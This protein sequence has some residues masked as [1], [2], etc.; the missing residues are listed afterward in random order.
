MTNFA[1]DTPK[2]RARTLLLSHIAQFS[3]QRYFGHHS[4][5]GDPE[6]SFHSDREPPVGSLIA[7]NAAPPSKWYLSWLHEIKHQPHGYHSYLLESIDDGELIWWNNVGMNVYDQSQIAAH[8]EWRWT[9]VQHEFNDKWKRAC[10][11]GRDAYMYLPMQ[12]EFSAGG[13]GVVLRLRVRHAF[14]DVHYE[15]HFPS[16]KKLTKKAMLEFYDEGA[17][18]YDGRAQQKR[19]DSEAKK[20]AEQVQ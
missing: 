4:F 8:P 19:A 1:Y 15:K 10:F 6:M 17:A 12:A 11:K 7:L 9:D 5:G 13:S 14:D 16:W 20:Q 3:L 18:F 2:T